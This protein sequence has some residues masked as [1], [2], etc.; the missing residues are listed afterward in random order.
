MKDAPDS[1]RMKTTNVLKKRQKAALGPADYYQ[2][3]LI[4][5]VPPERE[6]TMSVRINEKLRDEVRTFCKQHGIPQQTFITEAVKEVWDR[7]KK[8]MEATREPA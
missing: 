1:E 4:F 6:V 8:E 7:I 2:A 5:N 3:N